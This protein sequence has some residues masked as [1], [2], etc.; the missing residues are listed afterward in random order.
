M[1]DWA[2]LAAGCF[3]IT[4]ELSDDKWRRQEDLP[5]LWEEN[6]DALLA[7]PLAA[8]LGGERAGDSEGAVLHKPVAKRIRGG[9][10]A[11]IIVGVLPTN[12]QTNKPR[13]PRQASKAP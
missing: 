13:Q 4:L 3:D 6:R 2:Y 12:K 8:V 9:Q 11:A 1:Q 5:Q 10:T 7:L